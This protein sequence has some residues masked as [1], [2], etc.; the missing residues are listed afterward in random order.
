MTGSEMAKVG[1]REQNRLS[2][3]NRNALI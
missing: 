3:A 1:L 2:G